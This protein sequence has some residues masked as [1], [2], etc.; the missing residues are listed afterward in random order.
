MYVC[1]MWAKVMGVIGL[2]ANLRMRTRRR[3]AV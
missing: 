2:K 3:K 1:V